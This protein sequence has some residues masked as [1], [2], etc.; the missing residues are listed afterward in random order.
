MFKKYGDIWQ[1]FR[2]ITRC[3]QIQSGGFHDSSPTCRSP[4]ATNTCVHRLVLD[5][6]TNRL[7]TRWHSLEGSRPHPPTALR[8]KKVLKRNSHSLRL[9]LVPLLLPEQW[10]EPNRKV[11]SF[12]SLSSYWRRLGGGEEGELCG[13]RQDES[14]RERERERWKDGWREMPL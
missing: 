8:G 9:Y 1:S 5:A 3:M 12:S 14:E 10:E 11:I 4:A 13:C 6:I 2:Q 7:L